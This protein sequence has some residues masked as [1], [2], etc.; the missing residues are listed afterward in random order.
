MFY[1]IFHSGLFQSK[2]YY[3]VRKRERETLRCTRREGERFSLDSNNLSVDSEAQVVQ[4]R[5]NPGKKDWV[6]AG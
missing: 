4:K 2:V 6:W 1:L 3:V 5:E